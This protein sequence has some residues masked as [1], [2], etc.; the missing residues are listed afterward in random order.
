MRLLFVLFIALSMVSIGWAGELFYT[1]SGSE[2]YAVPNIMITNPKGKSATIDFSGDQ[3]TFSG[4]LPVDEAAKIFFEHVGALC[5]ER[6]QG[7]R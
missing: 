7:G 5:R 2:I 3:V 4:E 1:T 6:I